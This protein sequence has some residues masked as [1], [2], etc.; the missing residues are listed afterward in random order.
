MNKRIKVRFN[1]SRGVNYMKWKVQY[2]S[3]DVEYH[4]PTEAQLIMKDCQLKNSRKTAV[5][6]FNGENKS[7]CAWILCDDIEIKF[8]G[9]EQFDTMNLDLLK[10]N[11]KR[12]PF[13]VMNDDSSPLD[14][15][16]FKEIGTVDYKL[17]VTKF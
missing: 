15:N 4:S 11:P 13:W 3:G 5:R 10:Y 14:G 12:L 7:V 8:D 9:Y 6:I 17:Y 1:L 2:P 16:N